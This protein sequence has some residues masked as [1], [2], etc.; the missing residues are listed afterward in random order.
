MGI[1]G[2]PGAPGMRGS[3]P[4]G[5]S[6]PQAV[7]VVWNAAFA[8]PHFGHVL[9]AD[10]LAGLKHIRFLSRGFS[11]ASPLLFFELLEAIY[12]SSVDL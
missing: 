9:S 5:S 7:Q 6:V 4:W 8:V 10:A 1:P 11:E 12:V 2:A 3:S